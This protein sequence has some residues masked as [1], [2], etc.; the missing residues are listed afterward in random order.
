MKHIDVSLS[1]SLLLRDHHS[2]YR[3]LIFLRGCATVVRA[4]I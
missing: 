1:F 3:L 4:E 2:E